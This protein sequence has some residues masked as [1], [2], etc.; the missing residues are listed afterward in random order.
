MDVD[1]ATIYREIDA[2]R[3]RQS[4]RWGGPHDWGRGDCSSPDVP[5]AVKVAVLM[6]ECGEVAR[7]VLQ[8]DDQNLR[9]ELIQVAAIAT[10]WLESE[11]W[12]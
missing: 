7:A 12:E 9:E 8:R 6:E 3:A 11:T 2:E 4:A 5:V 10:A 1:R